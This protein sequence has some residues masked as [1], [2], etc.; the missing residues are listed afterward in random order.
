[1]V[2]SKG[3]DLEKGPSQLK[4]NVKCASMDEDKGSVG[5][6]DELIVQHTTHRPNP[7]WYCLVKDNR[8]EEGDESGKGWV[9][10]A[11]NSPLDAG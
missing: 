9:N 6:V 5:W 11:S 8:E 7:F 4:S 3:V 2:A 10:N 1:M